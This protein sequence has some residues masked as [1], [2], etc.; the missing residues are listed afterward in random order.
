MCTC[1]DLCR[2]T[3]S[4]LLALP[5]RVATLFGMR[6]DSKE[7]CPRPCPLSSFSHSDARVRHHPPKGNNTDRVDWS[8][9][10]GKRLDWSGTKTERQDSLCRK[11]ANTEAVKV[12]LHNT[13]E[14]E[15]FL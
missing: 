13:I 7:V 8:G 2:S 1:R 14:R 5:S 6:V 10:K 4:I 3:D 11:E 12:D 15:F 9:T